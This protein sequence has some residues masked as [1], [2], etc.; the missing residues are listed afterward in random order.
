MRI[1]GF[2]PKKQNIE[3]E[4]VRSVHT[5][6]RWIHEIFERPEVWSG[7]SSAASANANTTATTSDRE[8][9]SVAA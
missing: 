6:S 5:V 1:A 7:V 8:A 4:Y 2:V 3:V 9:A